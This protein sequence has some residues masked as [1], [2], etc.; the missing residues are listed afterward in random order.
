MYFSII[1]NEEQD[2]FSGSKN[3]EKLFIYH[4]AFEMPYRILLAKLYML[5]PTFQN[6]IV[7]HTFFHINLVRDK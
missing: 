6:L 1:K 4:L 2:Y 7:L 3:F 5:Y